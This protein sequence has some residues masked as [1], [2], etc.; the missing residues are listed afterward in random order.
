MRSYF[1]YALGL[2]A[3]VVLLGAIGFYVAEAGRN[4]RVASFSDAL[5]WV[6]VTMATVG[7]G[8]IV[9]TTAAGRVVAV[10]LF[11]AGVGTLGIST[12]AIAA[13]LIRFDQFDALR[14]RRL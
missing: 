8:D 9:P 2:V 13:Y 7:Y 1:G 10:F 14:L 4:P 3:L 5:W 12:A 6:L 11:V